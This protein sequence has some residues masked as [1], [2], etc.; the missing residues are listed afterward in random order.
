MNARGPIILVDDSH[1][2][3]FI[4]KRLLWRAGHTRTFITFDHAEE[5]KSF[6]R[7]AVRTPEV[8]LL[9]SAVFA[10][11][12]LPGLD[13]FGLLKWTRSQRPFDRIT[14]V[15]LTG[16]V[17]ASDQQMATSLGAQH[18][19]EKFPAPH[20]FSEVLQQAAASAESIPSAK[21]TGRLGARAARK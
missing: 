13:G 1:D 10:D 11:K 15:V 21:T 9:P 7:A 17:V 19:F 16:T 6:L 3:L 14:F 2:D 20:V 18:F 8:G 4:L 12:A 5:A